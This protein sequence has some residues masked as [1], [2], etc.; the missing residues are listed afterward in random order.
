MTPQEITEI[1]ELGEANA[2]AD[3]F[4]AA[5]SHLNDKIRMH[6]EQLGEIICGISWDI[7]DP[8][9]SLYLNGVVGLGIKEPSHESTIDKIIM[10][11]QQ[12]GHPFWLH[13]SPLAQPEMLKQWIEARGFVLT[14]NVAKCYRSVEPVQGI[15]TDLKVERIGPEQA[16]AF[17]D[18]AFPIVNLPTH[19]EPVFKGLV[20]RPGWHH[21]L[22]FDGDTPVATAALFA[23]G[24][25]G[26]LGWAATLPSHRRRGAQSALIAQRIADA[27][28]LGCRWVVTETSE[29]TPEYPSSS[30]HNMLR[31]GFQLA[32]PRPAYMYKPKH[33]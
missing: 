29:E 23:Q 28:E 17:A 20:G 16:E 25:I 26:W 18:I 11:Y 33:E 10:L 14:E 13:L 4:H 9:W 19:L 12:A 22:A 21:Y 30:Y 32:Y 8:F 6:T 2:Y 24:E 3:M 7:D 1:S 31:T 5:S 27:A 15:E